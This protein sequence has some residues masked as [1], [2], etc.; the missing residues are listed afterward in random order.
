MLDVTHH[1]VVSKSVW[2][3]A[4]AVR[5]SRPASVTPTVTEFAI[6]APCDAL[7]EEVALD[8][9]HGS[10][11]TKLLSNGLTIVSVPVT[12]CAVGGVTRRSKV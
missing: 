10:A 3:A 1:P 11:L 5:Q 4:E 6:T 12:A 8:P 9:V 2:P 7:A